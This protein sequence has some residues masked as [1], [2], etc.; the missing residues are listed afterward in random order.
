M[1]GTSRIEPCD[2]PGDDAGAADDGVDVL[3]LDEPA[4]L[5]DEHGVLARLGT[6]LDELDR[7]SAYLDWRNAVRWRLSGESRTAP[8]QRSSAPES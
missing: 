8:E 1:N 5:L 3:A 2:L 7:A 4:R 6:P